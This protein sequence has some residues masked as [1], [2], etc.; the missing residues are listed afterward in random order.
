MWCASRQSVRCAAR[1]MCLGGCLP[2]LIKQGLLVSPAAA[3]PPWR[4][5]PCRRRCAP[6]LKQQAF[7]RQAPRRRRR[8]TERSVRRPCRAAAPPACWAAAAPPPPRPPRRCHR[9]WLAAVCVL[10][11]GRS[12][13]IESRR[14][15]Q[16]AAST[17]DRRSTRRCARRCSAHTTRS[18]APSSAAHHAA[19]TA[20]RDATPPKR[21]TPPHL[22]CHGC[23]RGRK[24]RTVQQ[25]QQPRRRAKRRAVPKKASSQ[26]CSKHIHSRKI[27]RR[28][29]SSIDFSPCSTGCNR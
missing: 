27:Q 3:A 21:S 23:A 5:C 1:S 26:P 8:Q 2:L 19:R 10:R 15:Q 7:W 20:D 14:G 17:T 28:T 24:S 9:R 11:V 12:A 6:T 22:A 18:S 25:Q 16:S 13:E 4:R 29:L